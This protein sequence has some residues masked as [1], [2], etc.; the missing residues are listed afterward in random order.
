MIDSR[1]TGKQVIKAKKSQGLYF[2]SWRGT[3]KVRREIKCLVAINKIMRNVFFSPM[4]AS[5]A[6]KGFFK[7]FFFENSAIDEFLF[8]FNF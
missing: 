3:A 4:S 5:F 7:T 6:K 1:P 2:Y 8:F